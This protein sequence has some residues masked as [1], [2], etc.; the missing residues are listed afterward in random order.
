MWT[1]GTI[2]CAGV[3][4]SEELLICRNILRVVAGGIRNNAW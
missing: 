4:I 2:S 3:V 1:D